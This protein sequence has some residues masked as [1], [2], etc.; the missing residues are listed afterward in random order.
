LD[1]GVARIDVPRPLDLFLHMYS[2]M[3]MIQD[4]LVGFLVGFRLITINLVIGQADG[5]IHI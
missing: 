5:R 2:K 1:D 4:Q 3:E